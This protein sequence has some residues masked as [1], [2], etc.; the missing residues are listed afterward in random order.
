MWNKFLTWLDG[1][2]R[3]TGTYI[4]AITTKDD[5][6]FIIIIAVPIMTLAT[7]I[8]VLILK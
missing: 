2:D 6:K 3:K 5:L 4:R 7:L 1:Y 8:A